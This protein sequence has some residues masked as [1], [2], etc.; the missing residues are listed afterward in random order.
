MSNK[1]G[2][3]ADKSKVVGIKNFKNKWGQYVMPE[4]ETRLRKDVE[5]YTMECDLNEC[6]GIGRY[7]EI[8]EVVCEE[9]G[10]VIS[11]KPDGPTEISA[12]SDKYSQGGNNPDGG[13]NNRGAS[14]HPLM[15]VPSLTDPG[16]SGD[17]GMGG[18]S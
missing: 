8:G 5:R 14:G 16:P 18:R 4:G 6:E 12:Y 2:M 9:C 3:R 1:T 17:D 10:R 7:D 11:Q 15:R 13:R